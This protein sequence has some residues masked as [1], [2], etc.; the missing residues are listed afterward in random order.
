VFTPGGFD[1][2]MATLAAMTPE[3]LADVALMTTV[4]ETYDTWFR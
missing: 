2:Y 4:G 3:Q 1:Q